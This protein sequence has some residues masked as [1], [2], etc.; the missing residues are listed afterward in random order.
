MY[1]EIEK[2][3]KN[4]INSAINNTNELIS[5]GNSI[6]Q[7]GTTFGQ[8]VSSQ[9]NGAVKKN[10]SFVT[11]V[12]TRIKVIFVE[13]LYEVLKFE[14]FNLVSGIVKDIQNTQIT[15]I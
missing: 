8:N 12:A 10:K 4:R 5:S 1:Y 15:K 11:A 2:L 7:S 14:I 3:T 6:L 13:K 9:I